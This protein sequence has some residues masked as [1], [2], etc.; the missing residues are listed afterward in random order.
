MT[1]HKNGAIT[2]SPG[3]VGVAG[4][5]PMEAPIAFPELM[6]LLRD[7]S[8][9]LDK[10]HNNM[11]NTPSGQQMPIAARLQMQHN[12][13]KQKFAVTQAALMLANSAIIEAQFLDLIKAVAPLINHID[14]NSRELPPVVGMVACDIP[15]DLIEALRKAVGK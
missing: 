3:A 14:N 13:R 9:M 8:L 5:L 11:R 15:I 1:E 6:K 12:L 4:N 7:I 2:G 10:L